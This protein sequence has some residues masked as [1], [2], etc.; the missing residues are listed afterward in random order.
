M[1]VAGFSLDRLTMFRNLASQ[2]VDQLF[3][4]TALSRADRA[5]LTRREKQNLDCSVGFGCRV[6]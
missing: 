4:T 3:I 1:V 2:L 6:I 5:Q